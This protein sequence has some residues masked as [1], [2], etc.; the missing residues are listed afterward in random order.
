MSDISQEIS[1]IVERISTNC[2][3]NAGG[4]LCSVQLSYIY[5]T[6]YIRTV[7]VLAPVYFADPVKTSLCA[8]WAEQHGCTLHPISASDQPGTK[9][10]YVPYALH[11][12]PLLI[13]NCS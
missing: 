7:L 4:R 10:M 8:I 6:A 9:R 5:G 13:T 3:S 11:Y 1:K 2:G 12:N